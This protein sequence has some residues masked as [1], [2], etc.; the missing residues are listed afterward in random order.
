MKPL[1]DS[2]TSGYF[3]SKNVDGKLVN[4]FQYSN[5]SYRDSATQVKH[6]ALM[7]AYI[8]DSKVNDRPFFVDLHEIKYLGI[9][10]KQNRCITFTPEEVS[11][12][13]DI[14]DGGYL[15]VV[16]T[17]NKMFDTIYDRAYY[18]DEKNHVI[19][20]SIEAVVHNS[21][22]FDTDEAKKKLEAD[23]YYTHYNSGVFIGFMLY[24]VITLPRAKISEPFTAEDIL[25][26][27]ADTYAFDTRRNLR[28]EYST[29]L[30]SIV[31]DYQNGTITEEEMKERAI[32]IYEKYQRLLL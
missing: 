27:I 2:W 13:E 16:A 24:K 12:Q 14:K 19:K 8:R 28:D 21:Q 23:S 26:S 22:I 29:I 15:I 10:E 6:K 11:R 32:P 31:E 7:Q 18:S 3:I 9:S 1:I 5:V 17:D 30:Q 25:K 4:K 20:Q